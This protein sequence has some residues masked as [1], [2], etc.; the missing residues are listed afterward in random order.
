[1]SKKLE[2]NERGFFQDLSEEYAHMHIGLLVGQSARRFP[3][4]VFL[5]SKQREV[6]YREFYF[7]VTRCAQMFAKHGGTS[8][9]L[10][11]ENGFDFYVAYCAALL[12]GMV[13]IPVNTFL[14]EQEVVQIIDQVKPS[15]I[16][17]S[18][19]QREKYKLFTHSDIN[20]I[21]WNEPVPEKIEDFEDRSF[22]VPPVDDTAFILFTSGTTGTPKGVMLSSKNVMSNAIQSFAR[23]E[24]FGFKDERFLAALP[25]FHVFSQMSA[26]W[27]PIIS[28]STI[29]LIK[30]IERKEL[31]EGFAQKPTTF[32]A[33]P[34]LF[35]LLCI[36][37]TCNLDSIKLFVCGADALPD[38]I[39]DGFAQL[40]GR[41]IATGYGL[42]EASPVISFNAESF[43][44]T[45]NMVGKPLEGIECLIKNE[46]GEK[47]QLGEVGLLWVKG[48]NIMQG[49]FAAPEENSKI[50]VDGWLNTGDYASMD[51][52]GR[53]T[54]RGREKDL[55]IN[56]GFKIYPQEVE[57]ILMKHPAV[58]KAAVIG[59]DNESSGQVPIAFVAAKENY[60]GL[61]DELYVLC[62]Q[63]LAAYKI[64]KK[65]II[66]ND[67][68]MNYTGKIDK[69]RLVDA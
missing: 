45:S 38:K 14:H 24:T 43:F 18:P 58:F 53:L 12:A 62:N 4:R 47:V 49:Y 57:N 60:P 69:K 63:S 22:H 16:M 42:S 46:S 56:K 31:L 36:M 48:P 1:M 40:Y 3:D 26:I 34:A 11:M 17:L 20:D 52:Q 41:I 44:P 25:L 10:S 65:I 6:T 55:I 28:C 21:D 64:P 2:D 35:G 23:M 67:L 59:R 15:I 8:V 50:L 9:L 33:V 61:S 27:L 5:V 66:L 13:I 54:I 19:E 7:R 51:E 29:I 32:F 37:R 39:R 68:P 30:R